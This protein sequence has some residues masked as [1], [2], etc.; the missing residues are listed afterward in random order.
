MNAKNQ[1]SRKRR[2]IVVSVLLLLVS[3]T[4]C[5]Q[6][7]SETPAWRQPPPPLKL[8]PVVPSG[9]VTRQALPNGLSILIL[10][11]HRVPMVRLTLT[12]KRGAG[13][14]APEQAGLAEFTAELM[15]RGAGDRDALALAQAVDEIGASL[16]ISAGWDSMTVSVEGLSR[17]FPRLLEIL[18]DVVRSPRMD[19]EE[20]NKTRREQLAA[21]ESA[22]DNPGTLASWHAM[23]VLYPEHRYGYPVSGETET[24]EKLEAPAARDLHRRYF[25]PGNAIASVSGDIDPKTVQQKLS[26]AF[27]D[28]EPG[29]E[30]AETPA[31]PIRTPQDRRVVI[32]N[33]PDL[34]QAR[35]IV[36]QDGI[37]RTDPRR[38]AAGLLNDT[39]GG[40]GFSSRLMK[41]L[42]SDEGLTYGVHSGFVLRRKPGPF[43]VSTFTR[44][45]E[46][47]RAVDLVL[48]QIEAIRGPQPQTAD[49]LAKAKSYSAG[50]FALGLETSAA[51][52]AAL[53]N[54]EVYG[55]PPDSLDTYRSRVNAVTV[56]KT[57]EVAE[58]LLHPGRVAIV[59]LGPADEL[60]PLMEGLGPIEIIE[61]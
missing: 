51:L 57:R 3:L 17:D 61:P 47:R 45:A 41:T 19:V 33:K 31:P 9:A 16:A 18:R 7:R 5:A 50:Q 12:S 8:G 42:R 60:R 39:L 10:E 26:D 11:D 20:A 56:S 1:P 6:L 28:W 24:V 43:L 14:V 44:V 35:V 22:K 48:S 15:N 58:A 54:L 2:A 36:G 59:L 46:T 4:G 34:V 55:L 23:K 21:L 40:S 27:A 53:V 38:I 25:V 29:S 52:A 37:Q 32:V 30:P 13:A 49:E